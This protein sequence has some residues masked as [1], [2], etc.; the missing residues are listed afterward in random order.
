[1]R[2]SAPLTGAVSGRIRDVPARWAVVG[3]VLTLGLVASSAPFAAASASPSAPSKTFCANVL[4]WIPHHAHVGDGVD[5]ESGLENCGTRA[6]WIRF[7]FAFTGPCHL[8]DR[9]TKRYHMPAGAGFGSSALFIVPCAGR[10]KLVVKAFH[11]TRR[12][13]RAVRHMRARA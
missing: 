7:E 4:A 8:S 5:V 13:D 11:G 10:Y 3:S 1:M 6:A 12:L 2:A 9:A